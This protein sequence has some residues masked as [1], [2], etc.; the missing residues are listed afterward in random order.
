MIKLSKKKL[1][2]LRILLLKV[3]K[4]QLMDYFTKS[5]IMI[6]LNLTSLNLVTQVPINIKMKIILASA[7]PR[8]KALLGEITEKFEVVPA[9]GE[10]KAGGLPPEEAVRK[11]SFD[12]AKE[13]FAFHGDDL[14]IGADTVVA[15]DGRIM[16]KPKDEKQ[17]FEML[18][19]LSGREHD[20][21][22]GVTVMTKDVTVTFAEKSGVLFRRLSDAEIKDY[23]ATGSPMD[24]AGAYGVQDSGFVAEV[25]G[26]VK[27][28][29]GLP[30][31]RL[32]NILSQFGG[33][34]GKL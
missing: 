25:R 13:V 32:A 22:T 21:Y 19:A 6:I 5:L 34:Y 31:E 10:E 27:N 3:V 11:L 29:V 20:V 15:L 16:G 14:V 28:V 7:S 30:V 9:R 26:S 23:I 18:S 2:L 4:H 17:A 8:R 12:K 1:M 24:K 33:A